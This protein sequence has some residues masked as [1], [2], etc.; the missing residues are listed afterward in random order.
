MGRAKLS[1]VLVAALTLAACN[2][3][4]I[5][6]PL[7]YSDSGVS[8][9]GSTMPPQDAGVDLPKLPDSGV[10]QDSA[11]SDSKVPMPDI[12]PTPDGAV[13]DSG[14]P[15]PD[16]A[17]DGGPT[18]DGGTPVEGGPVKDGGTPVEGGPVKDG[19]MP[20]EGGGPTEGGTSKSD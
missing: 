17:T 10:T 16:G 20:V 3:S 19:G 13:G 15:W 5:P 18:T 1:W 2:V 12:L 4:P 7:P 9:D 11:V 8:K 14:V 6:L